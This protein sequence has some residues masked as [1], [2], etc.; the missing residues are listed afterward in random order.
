MRCGARARVWTLVLAV[1]VMGKGLWGR[2][3]SSKSQTSQERAPPDS[4]TYGVGG[5]VCRVGEAT[6]QPKLSRPCTGDSVWS[7]NFNHKA[8]YQGPRWPNKERAR[9]IC[10]GLLRSSRASETKT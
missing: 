7:S 10:L 4:S 1:W 5:E 9:E 8:R 2:S 6:R 3:R